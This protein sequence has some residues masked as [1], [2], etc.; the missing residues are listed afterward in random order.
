MRIPEGHRPLAGSERRPAVGA[1]R[2]GPADAN[3]ALTVTVRVRR[4]PG[5]AAVPGQE[6]WAATPPGQ[7]S[8]V[9]RE[10]FARVY[11]ADEADLEQVVAFA[12]AHGLSVDQTDAARRVVVLSGTVAQMNEAFGVELGRY[13]SEAETYRGR[14]GQVHLPTDLVEVVE[15]VFGLD[16]RRMARR[17]MPSNAPLN[18][19]PLTP[20]QVA[21]DLYEFPAPP[22]ASGQ[23]IGVIEFS[24]PLPDNSPCGFRQPDVDAFFAALGLSSPTLVSVGVDGASNSPSGDPYGPDG[25]VCLDI[26]VA[27]SV[28]QG[29]KIAVYFA[30]WTEQGWIDVITTAVF[31]G[32]NAPSVL[33]ISWGWPEFQSAAGLTWTQAA[34]D[35]VSATFADASAM[36]VTVLAA[37]GDYGTDCGIGDGT[38]HVLYP[39]SDPWVTACGGTVIGNVSGPNFSEGTWNDAAVGGGATGGGIS[40]VFPLPGWQVGVGVPDSVNDRHQGRGIPDIA[41]NAS[42]NSGYNITADGVAS[43]TGGTSAVA[44]LYAGLVALLNSNLDW[45]VGYLNPTLYG[46]GGTNVFRD[47]ADGVSNALGT[48]P[49]YTSV[50]GWDACT[51]WGSIDGM[52]L[53]TALRGGLVT[54]NT[55]MI[56]GSFRGDSSKPGNFEA[57]VLEGSNLVHYW[58]DNSDPNLPWD[59]SVVV[60]SVA[61]AA[62]CLI[63]GSFRGDSSKPGNFEALVLEGSNLVH[64]W[65][66]NSDPNLPWYPGAIVSLSASGPAC[67]IEGSFRGDSSNPGNFEALVN[68]VVP[69]V[70]CNATI[71]YWR[72]NSDPKLPWYS[73]TVLV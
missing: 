33:S 62:A 1:R 63:E 57:L 2:V 56:E 5:A 6:H 52:Q 26:D 35:A 60:S 7:R 70:G 58:R 65:R 46:L 14:E 32:V 66:D 21:F 47:V 54:G 24:G 49:G 64:Y 61:T 27:G 69:I 19:A 55:S 31:D 13:E 17:A 36:G 71:H 48:A 4:R 59:R 20:S 16:N 22:N 3:E 67:M 72:D 25:E 38:A 29:A 9:A 68:Q 39:A 42:P 11:G 23:T 34:I 28:G 53:L 44:P 50:P 51:G 41:G 8:F 15:G 45:Q 12:Q 10:D 18:V 73:G 40:D 30:P 43:I 37:S